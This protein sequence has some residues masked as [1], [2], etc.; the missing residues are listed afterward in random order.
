VR[1]HDDSHVSFA[2]EKG[3]P[4]TSRHAD[5]APVV[6]HNPP[7]RGREFD[8]HSG[9]GRSPVENKKGG[10]GAANWGKN[11]ADEEL[12]A[13]EDAQAELA[14]DTPEA[15]APK[16]DK[17]NKKK[18]KKGKKPEEEEEKE[19]KDEIPDEQLKTLDDFLKEKAAKAVKLSLPPARAAGEGVK[20]DPKWAEA[21]KRED[22]NEVFVKVK[23]E[24]KPPVTEED[25]KPSK[26]SLR[27]R[28]KKEAKE[29]TAKKL[30]E[31]N[32]TSMFDFSAKKEGGD[33][34][35]RGRGGPRGPRGPREGGDN[36]GP[37]TPKEGGDNRGP[38][39]PRG[40]REGGDNRGPRGPRGPR[41]G[42]DNR[43]PN[44]QPR[45][46]K[47][48]ADSGPQFDASAFPALQVGPPPITVD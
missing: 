10:A 29:A 27:K 33:F 14:A 45:K 4:D 43:A 46:Y 16:S 28:R 31:E 34:V 26:S 21:V 6:K 18:K 24:T 3:K 7:A 23:E 11:S 41:E 25:K 42:G 40:P 38:R 36:R 12:A 19:K 22:N 15:G 1:R 17:K 9:T 37:R 32:I 35:P 39:G 2:E 48:E 47:P 8:R 44:R 13:A 5:G 20:A 30:A